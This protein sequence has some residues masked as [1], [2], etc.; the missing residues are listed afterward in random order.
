MYKKYS[1][2]GYA[3]GKF[4]AKLD[5]CTNP[6]Q[7]E[8]FDRVGNYQLL[9]LKQMYSSNY[10]AYM[11]KRREAANFLIENVRILSI[12]EENDALT[13]SVEVF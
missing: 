5:Q 1:T 12:N 13:L 2:D 9:Y 8:N 6:Q 10:S 11:N 3:G 4:C 7:A